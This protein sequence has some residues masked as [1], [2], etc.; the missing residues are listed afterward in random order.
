MKNLLNKEFKLSMHPMVPIML[1]LSFMVIIP[2][3]PYTVIFF[4]T[5]LAVFFTCLTGRENNDI[6]YSL[7]LPIA[8]KD[9]VKGRMTFVVIQEIVQLILTIPFLALGAKLNPTGNQAGMDANIALIGVGFI[10]YGVFNLVFFTQYYKNVNKVGKSFLIA[11]VAVF[12]L[13]LLDVVSTYTIPI[14]SDYVD[15]PSVQNLSYKLVTLLIGAVIFLILTA[16]AYSKSVKL[17]LKQD[18]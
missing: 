16:L 8:K 9:I 4:Y 10:I 7:M 6:V 18:L 5:T 3:Y 1:C 15:T 12:V 11:S 13:V 2:N 17:F 14:I